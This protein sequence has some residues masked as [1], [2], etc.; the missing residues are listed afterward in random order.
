MYFLFVNK[1][2]SQITKE[3]YG[4]KMKIFKVLFPEVMEPTSKFLCLYDL[5]W[6]TKTTLQ[7]SVGFSYSDFL[8]RRC[9]G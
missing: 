2:C 1:T 8:T 5:T 6:E 3:P 4:F 7:V 9:I